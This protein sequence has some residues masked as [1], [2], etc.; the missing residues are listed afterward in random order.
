MNSSMLQ[1]QPEHLRKHEDEYDDC[2]LAKVEGR[3]CMNDIKGLPA[4]LV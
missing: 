1:L 3:P 2:S 4:D